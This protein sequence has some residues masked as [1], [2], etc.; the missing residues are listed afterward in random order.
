MTNESRPFSV[1]LAIKGGAITQSLVC[2]LNPEG[3]LVLEVREPVDH[4]YLVRTPTPD[5][6]RNAAFLANSL[7]PGSPRTRDLLALNDLIVRDQSFR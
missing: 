3:N 1:P 5:E 4:G 7:F 6:V 2:D